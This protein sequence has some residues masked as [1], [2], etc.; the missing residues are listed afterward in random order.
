MSYPGGAVGMWMVK[1][2]PG[3]SSNVKN[4]QEFAP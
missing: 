2:Y 4:R 1:S 3:I